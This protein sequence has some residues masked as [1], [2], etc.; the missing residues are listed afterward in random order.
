MAYRHGDDT[1]ALQGRL[2]FNP[3]PHIDPVGTILVPLLCAFMGF[4]MFGWAKP[5]PVNA[6]RLDHPTQDFIKVALMG[7]SSN[8]GLAL[9]AAVLFKLTNT[10][11]I[12]PLGFQELLSHVFR[13]TVLINLFLAFFNLIPVFPLDGSQVVRGL[14]PFHLRRQYERHYPYGF[15]IILV[16]MSV[17]VLRLLVIIPSMLVYVLLTRLGLIW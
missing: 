12:F 10:L 6:A 5:V 2:T 1:A 7:P 16:L 8:L 11:G 3:L 4:P 9:A 14:L 17:G 15:M 13:F